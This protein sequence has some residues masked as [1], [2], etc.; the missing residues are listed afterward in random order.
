MAIVSFRSRATFN[1][2]Q[3]LEFGTCPDDHVPV[4]SKYAHF[5]DEKVDIEGTAY[6]SGLGG[7]SPGSGADVNVIDYY[8][9]DAGVAVGGP[10]EVPG[11]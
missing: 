9:D 8:V 1:A 7:F 3:I 11:H 4:L 5:P 2:A 10:A 6:P